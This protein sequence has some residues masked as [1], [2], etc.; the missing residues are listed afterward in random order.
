[1]RGADTFT[2]S[3]FT[4]HSLEDFVP[5][6]HPMRAIR[7]MVNEAL[8]KMDGL[9]AA[10]RGAQQRRAAQHRARETA[11]RHAATGVLQHP[12]GTPV[13]GAGAVQPAVPLVYRPG[14]GG[15]GVG[16]HGVHKKSWALAGA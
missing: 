10:V 6:D 1:M 5:A 2:E 9:F 13:D 4:L 12:L 11:A 7:Q 8:G 3:P 14:H 15:V 16:V